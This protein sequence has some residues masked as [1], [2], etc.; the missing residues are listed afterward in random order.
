MRVSLL[1]ML[2]GILAGQGGAPAN[3]V[4]WQSD[5]QGGTLEGSV[6]FFAVYAEGNSNTSLIQKRLGDDSCISWPSGETACEP[7]SSG[8][9]DIQSFSLGAG[10]Y[11][12]RSYVRGCDANCGGLGKAE[13]ECRQTLSLKPGE[14]HYIRRDPTSSGCTL[15]STPT[16]LQV[17]GAAKLSGRILRS[18]GTPAANVWIGAI[19]REHAANFGTAPVRFQGIKTDDAGQYLLQNIPEGDYYLAVIERNQ[20]TFFPGVATPTAATLVSIKSRQAAG[21]FDFSIPAR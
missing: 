2:A 10:N 1:I 19:R 21:R 6:T 9:G 7:A 8:N 15:N 5:A 14:T 18:D 4:V 17:L 11:E 13:Y 12:L 3:L 20:R 16:S